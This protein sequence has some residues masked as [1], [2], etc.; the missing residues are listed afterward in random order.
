MPLD[1]RCCF[2]P[3]LKLAVTG[4]TGYVGSGVIANAPCDDF[5]RMEFAELPGD[6]V[7]IHMAAVVSADR[8]GFL[9]NADI[10]SYVIDSVNDRHKAL[11]FASTN[12]VYPNALDCRVEEAPAIRDYYSAS[13]LVAEFLIRESLKRPYCI[14]RIA[15]VFGRGARH[16]NLFRAI[17]NALVQ[18]SPL[19]IHGSGMKRR[20]YIH[21]R[22]LA[23][24]LLFLAD[25]L[26]KGDFTPNIVNACYADSLTTAE[27]I[28]HVAKCSG[29]PVESVA[30]ENDMSSLDIR[31]MIPGP[32]AKYPW[33]WK[34]LHEALSAYVESF[35]TN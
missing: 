27:L 7:I 15:D 8:N 1:L 26:H 35:N 33:R 17:E 29:L 24:I 5:V 11:V 14:V 22:E 32:L 23:G 30:V 18:R 3:A 12:N 13:K 16:G 21:Q 10:D 28:A 19:T 6:S 25:T 2:S 20:S 4:A 31:T 34:S 9:I